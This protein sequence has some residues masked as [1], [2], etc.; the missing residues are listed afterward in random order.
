MAVRTFLAQENKHVEKSFDFF[1]TKHD[2]LYFLGF[3]LMRKTDGA[4][5]SNLRQK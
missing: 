4:L 3:F 2:L 5:I 1:I